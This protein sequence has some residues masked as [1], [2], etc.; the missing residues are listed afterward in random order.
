MS[1][2]EL[3]PSRHLKSHIYPIL[4]RTLLVMST[5]VVGLS[6]PFFSLVLSLIGS[7]LTMLVTL[8][9]PPACYL[10]ILRG[11][12]GR[13][14]VAICIIIIAVGVVS[15]SFGT[16]SALTKIIENLRK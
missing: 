14:E 15:S 13:I 3:L 12:V 5:L 8:I 10:S 9:L 16:Y 1:L 2:E 11:K 6:V 4:I 7:L